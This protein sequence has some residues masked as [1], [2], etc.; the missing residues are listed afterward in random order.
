MKLAAKMPA[1][2]T[3]LI[4]GSI[5]ALGL[6]AVIFAQSALRRSAEEKLEAL[7]AAR[8]AAL[9]DY[10]TAITEDLKLLS[11]DSLTQQAIAGFT[12]T[13]PTLGGEAAARKLYVED[14]G[15]KGKLWELD[16][17]GDGSDYSRMHQSYHP[18]F[19]TYA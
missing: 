17:A 3:A 4:A 18:W 15:N 6:I 2:V 5:V 9:S 10:L 12:R 14:N 13:F 19:K 16:D 11:A 7:V 8:T 1:A